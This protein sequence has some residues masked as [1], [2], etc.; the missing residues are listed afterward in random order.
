MISYFQSKDL[1]CF[2]K[3]LKSEEEIQR[4]TAL[5]NTLI[6]RKHLLN[7]QLLQLQSNS[8][9]KDTSEYTIRI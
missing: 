2:E 9:S 6:N 5:K 8:D 1:P 7:K 3:H 4:L